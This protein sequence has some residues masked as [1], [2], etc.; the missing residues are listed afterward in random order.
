MGIAIRKKVEELNEMFDNND[1]IDEI[2]DNAAM[3]IEY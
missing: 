1:D 3:E 2:D